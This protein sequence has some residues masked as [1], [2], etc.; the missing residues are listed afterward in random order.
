VLHSL[1]VRHTAGM[2]TCTRVHMCQP[3][4]YI[5]HIVFCFM[6]SISTF[7]CYWHCQCQSLIQERRSCCAIMPGSLVLFGWGMANNC[8][9]TAAAVQ[10]AT[11]S[12]LA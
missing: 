4:T 3:I 7:F 10:C 12:L 11:C 5:W 2:M 6:V 9:D 1:C 8:C